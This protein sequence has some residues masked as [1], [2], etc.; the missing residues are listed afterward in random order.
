MVAREQWTPVR[1]DAD[2][3]AFKNVRLHMSFREIGKA[4]ALERS[5]KEEARC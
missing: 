4:K 3:L 5:F 2:K 1:E